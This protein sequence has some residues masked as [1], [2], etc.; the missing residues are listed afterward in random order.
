M[1]APIVAG[2]VALI[3]EAAPG[4]TPNAI[5][6][7]LEFTAQPR[8]GEDDA[9]QGTGLLNRAARSPSRGSS[10]TKAGNSAL[11]EA[12]AGTA[13]WSHRIIWDGSRSPAILSHPRCGR[14]ISTCRGARTAAPPATVTWGALCQP[15]RVRMRGHPLMNS[16]RSGAC[17]REIARLLPSFAA[18]AAVATAVG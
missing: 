5:K 15:E 13:T 8:A 16:R 9:A 17:H 12:S 10:P 14:G 6:A 1:A 7:I 4:L 2:T 11:D 3:A 18:G